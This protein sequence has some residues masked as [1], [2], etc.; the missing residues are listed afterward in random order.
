M[1]IV[2][3]L[4]QLR[5][6]PQA[7]L[8]NPAVPLTSSALIGWLGGTPASSG[9]VVTE[10]TALGLPS[11]WRAVNLIAGTCS[12]LPLHAYVSSGAA[13]VVQTSGPAADLLADPHPDLT[14]FELWELG[15]G[16]VLTWG[17]AAYLKL[18]DPQNRIRELWW[19]EPSRIKY[20]RAKD[21]TKV[22]VLDGDEENSL[23]DRQVLHIP[24]FGY[25]G[26][27]GVSPIRAAREGLGLALAAEEYGARLFG[28]GSLATGILQTEQRI[29]QSVADELKARWKAGGT[30]LESAHD[31][32]V[33]GSGTKW[34]QLTIPPG[35][36]QFIESRRFQISEVA[37]MFG[38]PP[39]MLGET[40]KS[41]SWGTGIEEQNI[42]FVTYTLRSWLTRFEQRLSKMFRPSPEYAR[43]SVEGLLRGN[44]AA[45]S[46]FYRQLWELGVLSTNEVRALE[47]LGPV[48]G[49]DV[50]YRPLNMGVL[51]EPDP[52]PEPTTP[53]I[54]PAEDPAPPAAAIERRTH[55]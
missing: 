22:Y 50:R 46:A 18:R 55:A 45:R 23:S 15:Y 13:R 21:G 44:S 16:S 53:A 37:R 8:Q 25:D 17:N 49:G 1:T 26:T 31:I 34:Q 4:R 5:G 51:G 2:S 9:R 52:A 28:N 6:G 35:D 3:M 10:R 12:A 47:E 27:C 39:H 33:L 41:T 29:D 43:Y 38:I 30:G 40:E 24:G 11:V 19:I 32:R 54:E 7:G 48:E 36:A 20:G 14:P 42:G